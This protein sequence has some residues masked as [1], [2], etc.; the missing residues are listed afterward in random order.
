MRGDC[1]HI[2]PNTWLQSGFRPGTTEHNTESLTG[3]FPATLRKS[4]VIFRS[5]RPSRLVMR[6]C[7]RI[8]RPR[9]NPTWVLVLP[10]SMTRK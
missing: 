7:L 5:S 1:P 4:A 6:P 9:A 10:I 3:R 8:R 2:L